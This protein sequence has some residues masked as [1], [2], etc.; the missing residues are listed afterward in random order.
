MCANV[1]TLGM[2]KKM[3]KISLNF[4]DRGSTNFFE[5]FKVYLFLYFL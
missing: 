5:H 4:E 3:I 1:T 2:Q